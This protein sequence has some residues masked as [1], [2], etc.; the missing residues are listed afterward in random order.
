MDIQ[1]VPKSIEVMVIK[2]NKTFNNDG[3]KLKWNI[4]K[5]HACGPQYR[6][7]NISTQTV[8]ES[9]VIQIEKSWKLNLINEKQLKRTQT[10]NRDIWYRLIEENKSKPEEKV[11]DGTKE[12]D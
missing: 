3:L 1:Q 8:F 12:I 7:I 5:G 11:I 4:P 10:R 6:K 2:A 9:N